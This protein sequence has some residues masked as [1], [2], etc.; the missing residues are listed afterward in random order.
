MRPHRPAREAKPLCA[1]KGSISA[2]AS[3]GFL[4]FPSFATRVWP[5]TAAPSS[6]L[7]CSRWTGR[8]CRP[9]LLCATIC[10]GSLTGRSLWQWLA[11]ARAV[12]AP[13]SKP[14][15]SYCSTKPAA[16]TDVSDLVSLALHR[17]SFC[18]S[19]FRTMYCRT[20]PVFEDGVPR[21]PRERIRLKLR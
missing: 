17:R 18:Q 7:V 6:R 3:A 5:L 20:R 19:H 9:S 2:Y 11:G 8:C 10:L 13:V 14:P 12:F 21:V 15:V 4:M 16:S 1:I